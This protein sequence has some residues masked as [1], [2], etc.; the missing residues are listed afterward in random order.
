VTEVKPSTNYLMVDGEAVDGWMGAMTMNY[1][2]DDPGIL[3]TLKAGDHI[4]ATVY[5]GDYTLHK[6]HVVPAGAD[7][8]K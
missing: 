5:E 4:Q 3:K 8:K 6:V 2:V 7:K 1:Q